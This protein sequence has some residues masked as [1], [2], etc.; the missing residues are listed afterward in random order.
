MRVLIAAGG[1]GG[2]VMP[3][4]EVARELERRGADLLFVGTSRGLENRLVPERGY[5]LATVEVGALKGMGVGRV[6]GTLLGLPAA[7][8]RAARLIEEFGPDV[9]YGMGGYASGPVLLMAALKNIPV[10]VHEPNAVPGFA[11]RLLAPW[12]ARALVAQEDALR[13]FP[14]RRAEVVGVPVRREFFAIPPKTHE[15]PYTVLVT[16]GSQGSARLNRAVKEALPVLAGRKDLFLLHQT[17]PKEYEEVRKAYAEARGE[18]EVVPFLEDMPAAMA[19]ADLVVCRAGAVTLAELAAAGRAGLLVP[20]PHAA[21]QHQLRNARALERAEAA[22]VVLDAELSGSRLLSEIDAML[23]RLREME[24]AVRGLAQPRAAERVVAVL[25]EVA[26][27]AK[28]KTQNA[29]GKT[30]DTNTFAL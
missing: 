21:D 7:F 1:T 6:V 16:G 14:A 26:G 25:E 12:V 13:F 4:L 15:P 23:P 11:N 3:A 29:K 5:R 9:A 27:K 8:V 28:G 22:R 10:V 17:G 2:H 19:R 30:G 18:G 20:F 24:V